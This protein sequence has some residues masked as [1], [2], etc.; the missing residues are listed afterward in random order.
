MN[1]AQM[2][3]GVGSGFFCFDVKGTDFSTCKVL[4]E[5]CSEEVVLSR[6]CG[7]LGRMCYLVMSDAIVRYIDRTIKRSLDNAFIV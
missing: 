6:L 3:G 2:H 1:R 5:Y 7:F 4:P